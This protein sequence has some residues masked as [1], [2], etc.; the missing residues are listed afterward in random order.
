MRHSGSLYPMGNQPS[1]H[2][3]ARSSSI[4]FDTGD[5]GSKKQGDLGYKTLPNSFLFL[6]QDKGL[7]PSAD[8]EISKLWSASNDLSVPGSEINDQFVTLLFLLIVESGFVPADLT[9][10]QTL[11]NDLKLNLSRAEAMKHGLVGWRESGS[12]YFNLALRTLPEPVCRLVVVPTQA[13]L[14]VNLVCADQD[15]PAFA[16][17]MDPHYYITE[18]KDVSSLDRDFKCRHLKELSVRVKDKLAVPVRSHIL[19]KRGILNASLLGVPCEVVWKILEYLDTFDKLRMSETCRTLHN[20]VWAK[21]TL[22]EL[23]EAK[24]NQIKRSERVLLV[25]EGNFSFAVDLFKLGKCLKITATCLEAEICVEPGKSNVHYLDERGVRVLFGIDGT[26]LTDH[27]QLK[28]VTFSKILFNFPHVGG[29]MKIHLNRELLRGFFKS[30]ARLLSPGGRVIVSLCRGQGG[31]PADV[32]QRA[33][34]DSWQVVEMAAH[35][36]FVLAQVQPFHK[37]VFPGYTC[38]GY[39]SRNIGFHLE[40]A[41]VHVFKSTNDPCPAAPVEEWLNRTQLHTLETNCGRV[42][43]STIHSDMYLSNPLTTPRSPAH[44]VAEQFTAFVESQQCDQSSGGYWSVKMVPCDDIPIFVARRVSSESPGV[45]S[46]RRSLLEVLERVLP[47]VGEDPTQVSVYCGLSFNPT[48]GDFSLPPAVPQLLSVGYSA[49]HLCSDYVDYLRLLFDSED[50]YVCITEP[51]PACWS[52]GEW[53]TVSS[54]RTIYC[55]VS[56]PADSIVACERL[57]VRR[58][59]LAVFVE[60]LNVGDLAQKLFGVDDWREL[61]AEGVRVN[62]SGQRPLLTRASLYPRKY[63]FDICLSYG[64]TFPTTEFYNVL[65]QVAGKIVTDVKLV[66]EYV[67]AADNFRSR[68]YRITYQ[69]FDKALFRGRVVDIHQNVIG[70]VLS[71]KLGLTVC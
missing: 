4:S 1:Q 50:S 9:A 15:V 26:K 57:S 58:G 27:P 51:S 46:L 31:T 70:R 7:Q 47:L 33:W 42:E 40:G 29:K 23:K 17:V 21:Y 35:G 53:E 62:T 14:I 2:Q 56:Q 20:A 61:W 32:P 5:K 45:F 34:S 59:D 41:L 28:N 6:W 68:C 54:S 8:F 12:Y 44:F 18:K 49:Q 25:G 48:S 65:W 63:E 67:S 3:V 52:F 11:K 64:S 55:K 38:V 39:R 30:V 13:M 24:N 36:D 37:H 71:A 19:N 66:N 60:V 22:E 16:T 69:C 43:C 10:E